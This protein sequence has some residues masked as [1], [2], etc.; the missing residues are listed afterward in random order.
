MASYAQPEITHNATDSG[1]ATTSGA[2]TAIALTTKGQCIGLNVYNTGDEA[3]TLKVNSETNAHTV[4]AGKSWYSGIMNLTQFVVV[5]SGAEYAY[6][7]Q[8][9]A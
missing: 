2:N 6:S 5:E 3:F 8:I 9:V 7:A 1:A 4:P